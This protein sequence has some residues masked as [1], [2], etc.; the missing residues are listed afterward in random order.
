MPVHDNDR[1]AVVL[2]VGHAYTKYY[3]IQNSC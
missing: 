1:H 3:P 2:D